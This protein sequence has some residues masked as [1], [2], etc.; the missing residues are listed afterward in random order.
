MKKLYVKTVGKELLFP[1]LVIIAVSFAVYS[2]TLG[3]GF[4][5]DDS[6]QVLGNPWLKDPRFL[7]KIFSSG[8]WDFK[9]VATNYYR[10]MTHV[11]FM[12]EYHIFGLKPWGFHLVNIIFHTGSS[13][14]VFLIANILFRECKAPSKILSL[15]LMA[16]ILFA[17]HPIHTEPVAWIA[18]ITDLSYAFFCLMSFYLYMRSEN[19][20]NTRYYISVMAFFLGTLCKEPAITLP[21][22]TVAYDLMLNQKRP[23]LAFIVKRHAMFALAAASYLG[24]RFYALSGL[25]PIKS[26]SEYGS[27]GNMFIL[28]SAYLRKLVIPVNLKVIYWFSP[29]KSLLETQALLAIILTVVTVILFYVAYKKD[30]LAFFCLLIIVVPL[31]PSFYVPATNGPSLLGERYLYLPSVGLAMLIPLMT[32]WF[33]DSRWRVVA[34]SIFLVLIA[35]FSAGT[36]IRNADWKDNRSLFAKEVERSPQSAEAHSYLGLGYNEH[37]QYDLAIGEF[38]TTINLNLFV[39]DAYKNLGI[40]YCGNGMMD[41][42]ISALEESLKVK[43]DDAEVY[44]YLGIDYEKKGDLKRALENYKVAV[45]LNPSN[46]TFKRNLE[47]V[48]Q[49][50]QG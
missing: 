42:S 35:L 2:N 46:M 45:N 3:N 33:A 8:A 1:L 25:V 6:D 40:A 37:G 16:A 10:P 18:A 4:V 43:P 41:K 12:L 29:V 48:L 24:I 47:K 5:W 30:K 9:S 22:L 17:V 13:V 32:A 15:P 27:Y 23:G 49:E 20:F 28:I 36:M 44:N 38:L 19:K 21:A 50:I 34:F 14:L 39:E 7:P 11:I 31:L 26:T